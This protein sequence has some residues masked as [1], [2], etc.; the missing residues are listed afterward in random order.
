MQKIIYIILGLV[1]V[2]ALVFGGLYINGNYNDM[3][4][5]SESFNDTEEK[6][7]MDKKMNE[8]MMGDEKSGE[9][10]MN[11]GEDKMAGAAMKNETPKEVVVENKI[12]KNGSFIKIDAAHNA[13]GDVSVSGDEKYYYINFKDNFS[14]ANGPDLYV[15]L[16]SK[17][18]Y[19]N[20]AIGGVDTSKTLNVGKLRSISGPQTYKVSKVEFEKY[21]DSVIIWCKNFGVQFSRAE[22]K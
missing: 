16:S 1:L 22:L 8:K 3:S 20:I 13:S 14:S 21:S 4:Q 15:Y 12:T 18:E 9:V 19:K 2:G 11:K 5:V 6:T 7:V 10:M 17:Q